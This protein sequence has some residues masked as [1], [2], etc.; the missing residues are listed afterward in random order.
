MRGL[1]I[2]NGVGAVRGEVRVPQRFDRDVGARYPGARIV[3]SS[4]TVIL[5]NR[6]FSGI[7]L[8]C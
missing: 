1:D 4:Q 8:S 3:H 6:D 5:Y 2:S 7:I